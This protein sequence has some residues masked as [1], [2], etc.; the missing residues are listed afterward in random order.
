MIGKTEAIFIAVCLFIG[1]SSGSVGVVGIL[2]TG[3]AL[4]LLFQQW[5]ASEAKQAEAKQSEIDRQKL[6]HDEVD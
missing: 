6:E 5:K 2:I 1:I 3:G 4:V